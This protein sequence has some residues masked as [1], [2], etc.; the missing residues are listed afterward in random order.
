MRTACLAFGKEPEFGYLPV[1]RG[2]DSGFNSRITDSAG[3]G[4]G[5]YCL[6]WNDINTTFV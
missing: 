1:N 5:R 3:N 2:D 6:N 4:F